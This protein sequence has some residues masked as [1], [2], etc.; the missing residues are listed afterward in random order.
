MVLPGNVGQSKPFPVLG[1]RA[2]KRHHPIDFYHDRISVFKIWLLD[3]FWYTPMQLM[4]ILWLM[5]VVFYND[6]QDEDLLVL[7]NFSVIRR[8]KDQ[9]YLSLFHIFFTPWYF[10][11][12]LHFSIEDS[13]TISTYQYFMCILQWHKFIIDDTNVRLTWSGT[14]SSG[15]YEDAWFEAIS[16]SNVM[17]VIQNYVVAQSPVEVIL[18][19]R[20]KDE[21]IPM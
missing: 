2:R 5:G 11:M 19:N 13:T 15:R 14:S 6:F 18:D 12:V 21:K 10:C 4:A 20:A 17:P 1:S 16:L 8:Y 9:L 7:K 3:T